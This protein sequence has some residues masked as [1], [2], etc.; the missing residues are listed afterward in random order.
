MT[1]EQV[2][3]LIQILNEI[4]YLLDRNDLPTGWAELYMQDFR[5]MFEGES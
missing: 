5:E 1:S 2:Q 4:I 3:K